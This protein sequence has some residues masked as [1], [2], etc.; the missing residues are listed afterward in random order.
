MVGVIRNDVSEFRHLHLVV[1]LHLA[2]LLDE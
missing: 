1:L 2:Q